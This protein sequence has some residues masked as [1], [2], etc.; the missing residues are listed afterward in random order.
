MSHARRAIRIV[1]DAG[2]VA[3]AARDLFLD[4]AKRAV[5]E[6]GRFTVALAGGSTPRALYGLLA[7]EGGEPF[8]DRT[9][10]GAI[11]LFWGDERH[12]PPDHADSNYRMVRES[13]LSRVEIPEANVHR[14]AAEDPDA[15]RAADVYEAHLSK[16]FGTPAGEAPRFDLLLLGMGPD[17]HTASLFPGTTALRETKRLVAAPWVEKFST[18]RI[19]L[20]FPVVNAAR[21]T[22]FLVAG[23]DKAETLRDVLEGKPDPDRLP[24]QTVSPMNGEFVWLVARDAASLLTAS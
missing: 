4:S 18:Y 1:E 6:R 14:I 22:V 10:W 8:G 11:H 19:T 16:F 7:D 21:R 12:V 17:G 13:L 24:S 9:G 3:L 5:G 20:T 15:Q 23:K 2:A